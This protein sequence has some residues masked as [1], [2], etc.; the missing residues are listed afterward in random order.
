MNSLTPGSTL[1]LPRLRRNGDKAAFVRFPT[2]QA[3]GPRGKQLV[4]IGRA[5]ATLP[6][7]PFANEST[8]NL[9]QFSGSS[10]GDFGNM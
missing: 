3:K 4:P 7:V 6:T 5:L 8:G 2:S 9:C 1:K 10:T